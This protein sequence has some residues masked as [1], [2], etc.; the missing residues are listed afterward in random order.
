MTGSS[1]E[2]RISTH[3]RRWVAAVDRRARAVSWAGVGI[4]LAAGV[5]AALFLGIN[6]DNMSLIPDRLPSHDAHV[7]F[8]S[9]FLTLDAAIIVVIDAETPELARSASEQLEEALRNDREHFTDVYVPGGGSFFE[10]HGLLYRSPEDLEQFAEQMVRMQPVMAELERDPSIAQLAEIVQLALEDL[11]GKDAGSDE[12]SLV[13]DRVGQATVDVWSEPWLATSWEDILLR[14]SSIEVSTRRV[15]I[16]KPILEFGSV[17][18]ASEA[19]DAIHE[20]ASVR[21][22][23]PERGVVV[24]IT[25]NPALNY[26]EMVGLMWDIGSASLFCFLLVAGIVYLAVRSF[27]VMVA[28]IA[29]LLAGLVWTSSYAAIAVGHLNLISISFAVLFIG[30]GVDFG[31]HLGMSYASHRRLGRPHDEALDQA[32]SNI[33]GSLVLC[34][35]TTAI[36]FFVFVPT[37]YRG[38]AELGLIATGGMV[39]IVFLFMTLFP[40][41][42]SGWLRDGS[43]D[44]SSPDVHFR[45]H[46]WGPFE[47][48]P[49]AVRIAAALAFLGGLALLPQSRF[50]P[51]VINMRDDETVSVQAFNDLLAEPDTAPWYINLVEPDLASAERAAE[52]MRALPSVSRAISLADFVPADQDA[53]LDVLEDVSLLLDVPSGEDDDAPLTQ[54]TTEEQIAAIRDLHEFFGRPWMNERRGVLADSIQK[55]R[56][57]LAA[58]LAR[59]ESEDDP[60]QAIESLEEVLFASLPDQIDRLQRAINTGPVR[61]EDLPDDLVARMQ[62]EDG[63]SRVQVFPK[64][65]LQDLVEMKRFV[66]EVQAVAPGATGVVVNLVEFGDVTVASF[67]QALAS[68]ALAIML[69]LFLIWRNLLDVVLA[70][71]PLVLSAV[72]TGA[73]MVVMQLPFDFSN[74]IVIPLL[75]GIG[76]DSGI[77]LVHRFKA[78]IEHDEGLLGT[79]TARAVFYSA[80]TTTASFGSLSFS[81]HNGMSILG[82]M[83]T[84]GMIFTIIC[85]LIVLPALLQLRKR[86]EANS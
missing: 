74:V 73:A 11:E 83:L 32:I 81:G 52:R 15:I 59:V 85:N 69:L 65:H 38:I 54:K 5:H 17:F 45:F 23:V 75:F 19:M 72:L 41:L 30:L 80:V 66:R 43:I 63:R 39:V 6:S 10:D 70:M 16:A 31:I 26:E 55:L 28:V 29:T 60:G 40:A 56:G 64:Q 36:G 9:L 44:A 12:W 76:V 77:H 2:D 53:K 20:F 47:R 51:N 68:A 14:G 1:L 4:T 58:F 61:F 7:E 49:A 25:G 48:H 82:R 21:G 13:L 78:R 34:G 79:T 62:A 71:T 35:V 8:G 37:D 3:L 18:G 57:H 86:P 67:A 22:L 50:D 42:I 84:A 33:G 46:W 24:R 27:R